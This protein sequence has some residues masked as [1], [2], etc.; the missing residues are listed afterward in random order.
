MG[1]SW[2]EVHQFVQV[3]DCQGGLSVSQVSGTVSHSIPLEM[4]LRRAQS[5]CS[6][7]ITRRLHRTAQARWRQCSAG[8]VI[9]EKSAKTD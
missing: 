2:I 4:G 3:A 9:V 5:G 7:V 1:H 8:A 6:E